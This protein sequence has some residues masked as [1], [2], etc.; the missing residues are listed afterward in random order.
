V[1]LPIG[2]APN[3]RGVPWVTY[4]LIGAN[5]SVFLLVTVP[6]GSAAPHPGDPALAEYLRVMT[7]VVGDRVSLQEFLRQVSEYDLFVFQWGFRP[8]APAVRPLFFSLFLHGSVLHLAGNMLFLWI[9]GDNVEHRLGRIRY[10]VA[11]LGT[12]IAATLFHWLTSIGSPVPSIGASGAISGV[13]GFYF[14]WFPRN[15]VRLLWLFPPFFMDVFLVPARLVLGLY[16]VADNLLPFL[17]ARGATGVAYG[18]HIG[19]F[20]AGL[21]GAWLSARRAVT[22]RPREYARATVTPLRP[23]GSEGGAIA[24]AL[25]EGRC[26]DAAAAYFALPPAATRG[27]LAPEHALALGEWLRDRG[28]PEAALTVLRR[29]LR[30]HPRGPGLAEAHAGAGRIL[31]EDLAE[32]T[33]A[34]QHFLAALDL[35]PPP[36]VAAVARHGIAAVEALQKRRIGHPHV[37]RSRLH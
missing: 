28:H 4:L 30:D 37:P 1:I 19:G 17:L 26:A 15:Q 34:Y 2:D 5:V 14:L 21:G 6:L 23:R 10:L 13:L 16:L 18:A 36:E 31:L 9:Y 24:T 32:P 3:P 29:H 33:A 20:L 12:G 27:L 35:E 7:R 11:Y 25:A 22:A 8:A